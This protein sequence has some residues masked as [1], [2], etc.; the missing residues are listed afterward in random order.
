MFYN[1]I[2]IFTLVLLSILLLPAQSSAL[3]LIKNGQSNYVVVLS[4]SASPSEK[5][6]AE[7]LASI[8]QQMTGVKLPITVGDI[9]AGKKAIVIGDGKASNSLKVR[10]NFQALGDEGFCTK[11]VGENLVIAG[12]KLRGTMYGVYKFLQDQLGCKFYTPF[13]S[14]IPNKS[15]IEIA[16][17]NI[18]QKPD[19]EFRDMWFHAAQDSKWAAR[20]MVNGHHAEIDAQHGGSIK[21]G[22]FVHTFDSLLHTDLYFKDH[23]EYYGLVDG[24]RIPGPTGQPCLTNPDVL[25]TI[26][27]NVLKKIDENPTARIFSVSQNDNRNSCQCPECAK[28]DEEE[29]SNMGTVLRFANAVADEVAKKHPEIIIDTLAYEYTEKP[30]LI[31]KPRPNVMIRLCTAC[32]CQYHEYEKCEK[33]AVFVEHL[34]GW[35]KQTSN[36]YIWHYLSNFSGGHIAPWPDL[37]QIPLTMKMLKRQNVKGVFLQGCIHCGGSEAGEGAWMMDLKAYLGAKL[38]WNANA[39]AKAIRADFL[40]GFYGKAGKPIGEFL[41]YLD[42]KV[43]KENIHGMEYQGIG[44]YNV[45]PWTSL[46]NRKKNLPKWTWGL[47]ENDLLTPEVMKA[48]HKYFDEAKR[49]ADN[50]EIL[51]RVK[52]SEL[53]IDYVDVM[54]SVDK[55]LVSDNKDVKMTAY[56]ELKDLYDRFKANGIKLLIQG[57]L[58]GQF[59]GLK[60]QLGAVD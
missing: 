7:D 41:K 4:E 23:P 33:D 32:K 46:E 49:V 56:K 31:S 25:K 8:L 58:D 34:K 38:L 14:H 1:G 45:M 30:T 24:K 44:A 9:P 40:N 36:L 12:G 6:A 43:K 22:L 29:G 15:T 55:A 26:T 17:L 5:T 27:E 13:V 53:G 57:D 59:N 51:A 54:R 20:N 10:I 60:Q 39:D 3:T 2:L 48:A 16:D 50:P 19:F 47:V 11:T 35:Q 21:Y 28:V 42:D 52:N 18:K 37:G